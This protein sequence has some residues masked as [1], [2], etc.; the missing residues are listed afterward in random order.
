MN[1]GNLKICD[2]SVWLQSEE[3]KDGRLKLLSELEKISPLLKKDA[4]NYKKISGVLELHNS[5]SGAI[6]LL[7]AFEKIG[8]NEKWCGDCNK[9]N[10]QLFTLN[11]HLILISR[12]LDSTSKSD[13]PTLAIFLAFLK[14]NP[15]ISL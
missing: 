3:I 5:V 13:V 10:N 12:I 14:R 8:L 11:Q 9:L 7:K 1:R 4:K 6:H 15:N 2:H